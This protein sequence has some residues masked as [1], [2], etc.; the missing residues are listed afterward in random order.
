MKLSNYAWI[1]KY[2]NTYILYK[3]FHETSVVIEE[4]LKMLLE[5]GDWQ[6]LEYV[7]PTFYAYLVEKGFLVNDDIDESKAVIAEWEDEDTDKSV[8]TITVNPTMDCNMR[9]WYCYEEHIKGSAMNDST[10][11]SLMKLI[12]KKIED[13]KLKVIHLKFFG[14]EPLMYFH[15]IVSPLMEEVKTLCCKYNKKYSISF[16]TNGFLLTEDMLDNLKNYETDYPI[17]F[18]ISLDG[19]K[20]KHNKIKFLSKQK[21][22]YSVILNNLVSALYKGMFLRL[23]LNCTTQ[24]VYSFVDVANELRILPDNLKKLVVVDPHQVWQDYKNDNPE[25]REALIAI[26]KAFVDAGFFVKEDKKINPERCYADKGDG[27]VIN[28][29]GDVFSCTA[30]KFTEENREGILSENGDVVWNERKDLRMQ[31]RFGNTTCKKCTI[32]PLCHGKCSQYKL[33]TAGKNGCLC[34]YTQEEKER[35]IIS[36]IEFIINNH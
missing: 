19:N 10:L 15:E 11:H 24:N 1:I 26:R 13:E 29:N 34:E 18:Q 9:C 14:G 16:T 4:P 32:Y 31:K 22:T 17:S 30:R 5:L 33:E 23:R 8:Y 6:H 3:S 12:S 35:L 27:C 25:F 20:T 7:H 36:R 2:E 21:D 28:Y